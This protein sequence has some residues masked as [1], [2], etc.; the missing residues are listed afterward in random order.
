M[1]TETDQVSLELCLAVTLYL[2]IEG[3]RTELSESGS[4]AASGQLPNVTLTHECSVAVNANV[5][6]RR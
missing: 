4:P 3:G 1:H 6:R 5:S 2:R